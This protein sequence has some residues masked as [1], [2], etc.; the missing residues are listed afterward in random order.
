MA[1]AFHIWYNRGALWD[2]PSQRE[3]F[4]FCCI[5][6]AL[7]LHFVVS[8]LILPVISLLLD[9]NSSVED[10]IS[11]LEANEFPNLLNVFKGELKKFISNSFSPFIS[12]R[13]LSIQCAGAKRCIPITYFH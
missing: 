12:S 6:R 10:V 2:I 7:F 1:S 4:V 8:F 5:L 13:F 11:F 3:A 9:R